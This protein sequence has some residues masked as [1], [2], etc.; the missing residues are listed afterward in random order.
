MV[1]LLSKRKSKPIWNRRWLCFITFIHLHL[2]QFHLF[3]FSFLFVCLFF[4]FQPKICTVYT[5]LGNTVM[6]LQCW[7]AS[8]CVIEKTKSNSN[9]IQ[10]WLGAKTVATVDFQQ[11]L[12]AL[13]PHVANSI[14]QRLENI[15]VVAE[16]KKPRWMNSCVILWSPI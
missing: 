16:G 12:R 8:A 6:H 10:T 15:T 5:K 3:V 7:E 11:T 1:E 13:T 9:L 2:M 4:F 14:H